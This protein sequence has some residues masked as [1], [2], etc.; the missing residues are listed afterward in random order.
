MDSA[1]FKIK[2]RIPPL[3]EQECIV[4]QIEE[5]FSQLDDAVETLKKTKTQ[6]AVYRQSVLKEAFEGKYTSYFAIHKT[7][8]GDIADG[9]DGLRRGPFGGAIKK[10]FFV[11]SGYKVYEQGNPTNNDC[12]CGHY[13]ISADKYNELSSFQ[14]RSGDYIVSRSRTI[15]KIAQ[16]PENAELRVINQALMRICLKFEV[17]DPY[18]FLLQFQSEVFQRKIVSRGT[19]MG[20]LAGIKEFKRATMFIPEHYENQKR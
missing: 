18:Y 19:G 20:N 8:I 14:L 4:V 11:E 9:K 7:T 17:I 12:K 5:L 10:A 15:G 3:P 1:V 6:L 13:Y 2:V 16:L